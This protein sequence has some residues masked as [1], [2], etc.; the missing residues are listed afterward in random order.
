[1][2]SAAGQRRQAGP[3]YIPLCDGAGEDD[4]LF[5]RPTWSW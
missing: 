1:V 2:V 3:E 4:D 5:P